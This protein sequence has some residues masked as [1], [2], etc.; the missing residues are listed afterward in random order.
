MKHS[1]NIIAQKRGSLFAGG[2]VAALLFAGCAS[3]EVT[4]RERLVYDKLPR[5]DHILVYNF[6]STPADVPADSALA[7]QPSAAEGTTTEEEAALGRELG[8]TIAA[9]LVA[10]IQEMGLPAVQVSSPTT[11]QVNDIVIR[12]YLVSIEKGSTAARMT[13]GF[14]AGGSEM[15]AAVEGYQMTTNGLRKLGSG[16]TG[17]E[18]SK[19]PGAAVGGAAWLITGSPVGLIVGG[20]MKIYGEASGRSG[21]EGRAKATAKEIAEQLKVRFKEEGWIN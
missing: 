19:G 10:D 15:E 16:M 11:A 13:I 8:S 18:G 21:I 17:S 6:A 12:G 9:Q 7:G 4:N 5:P 20:G 3:T 14:G 1:S 2:I